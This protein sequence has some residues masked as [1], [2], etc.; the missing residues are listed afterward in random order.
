MDPA[1]YA[2]FTA[3]WI[4]AAAAALRP[5]G[6]LAVVTGAQ[7]A[8]RVQVTA[9]DAAG[10]TYVNSQSAL[11]TRRRRCRPTRPGRAQ[12]YLTMPGWIRSISRYVRPLTVHTG[13]SKY[14]RRALG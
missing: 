14:A 1:E 7:Q 5:G 6:Y 10:L 12:G 4:T 11:N 13:S 8:A 2:E 3:T 9:E